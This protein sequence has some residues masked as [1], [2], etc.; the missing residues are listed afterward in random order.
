MSTIVF[1]VSGHGF[2][3]ASRV[4][5][6]INALFARRADLRLI[7]RTPAPRWLF[8]LTVTGR[9][10][11]HQVETDTGV[12]QIDSLHLDAAETVRRAREFMATFDARVAAESAF[13]TQAHVTMVVADAPPLGV[14][15][16]V[17]TGVPTIVLGNF[18]WDWIYSR[19]AGTAEL[20][21][22]LSTI[23]AR[24]DGALRLPMHG[25]FASV[26]NVVELPFVARRSHREAAETRQ[27]LQLPRDERLVL[28][29]FGGYGLDGLDLE[30]LSRL[31]HYTVLVSGSVPLGNLPEGLRGGRR[32]SLMPCDESS[33]YA[34]G[35]R[36]EDLVKAVDVVVTK[37]GYGIIAECLANDTALLYTSRGDFI[38][39]PVLV[40]A[41]PHFLRASFIDHP[42]LFAGRW[43]AHLD[44]VLAQ[45]EPLERPAVN[46]AEVA[47]ALLLGI[48]SERLCH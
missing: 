46:G 8:D 19:Y 26:G 12:V 4:I 28:V 9:V 15:A 24:A 18:T 21:A 13:L 48:L 45:P 44:A 34:A 37:P 41:M 42:D 11:Y 30:A 33:M 1:Y 17:A 36:Y 32:G 16:G 40:A 39:Y 43:R 3:H 6:V 38:E 29:S 22:E 23:Y 27:S 2:G 14:A 5:E 7:I 10:E 47:A 35:V 25:G 31:E 20:V